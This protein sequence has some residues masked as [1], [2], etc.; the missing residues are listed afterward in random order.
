MPTYEVV[1]KK[2]PA[3]RVA[4]IR[5]TI[6]TF[7]DQGHLWDELFTYLEQNRIQ[8]TGRCFALYHDVEYKDREVDAEV[9]APVDAS[10]HGSGR[11]KVY[12]LP[13]VETMACAVH[14]GPFNML[15]QA[16]TSLMQ[17]IQTNGYRVVG[18]DRE[19]YLDTGGRTGMLPQDDPSYVTEIQMPVEKM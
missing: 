3:L 5:T 6:P 12:D 13:A 9:C 14:H 15:D 19:V 8:P 7:P 17:W 1:I 11:V 18:P 4:S 10:A 16:Y 2:V